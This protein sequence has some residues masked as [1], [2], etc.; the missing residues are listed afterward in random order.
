MDLPQPDGPLSTVSLPRLDRERAV[1][2]RDLGSRRPSRGVKRLAD[3][4]EPNASL[5]S[6]RA[7]I[8]P[9]LLH[10]GASRRSSARDDGGRQIA[11]ETDAEI[12]PMTTTGRRV[13]LT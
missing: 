10:H 5:A 3:A 2:D 1:L 4:F 8:R 12:I 7:L 13:Q 11:G 6:C 9:F